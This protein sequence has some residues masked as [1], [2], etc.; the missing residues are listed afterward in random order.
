M[1]YNQLKIAFIEGFKESSKMRNILFDELKAIKLFNKW[2]KNKYSF[3]NE[4]SRL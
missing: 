3:E 2:V 1:N 4:G